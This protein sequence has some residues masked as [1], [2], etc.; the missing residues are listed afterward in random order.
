MIVLEFFQLEE[1]HW[2]KRRYIYRNYIIIHNLLKCY[3]INDK[4][5]EELTIS[6]TTG[7][8]SALSCFPLTAADGRNASKR[9]DNLNLACLSDSFCSLIFLLIKIHTYLTCLRNINNNYRFFFIM[10]FKHSS[11][12][13][14]LKN[15]IIALLISLKILPRKLKWVLV[16][17]HLKTYYKNVTISMSY[18]LSSNYVIQFN[19]K[20]YSL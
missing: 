19:I 3:A 1:H 15:E 2:S 17:L 7:V 6:K 18:F 16:T 14:L 13:I 11:Y 8:A 9:L 4:W 12:N 20:I 10:K 5:L